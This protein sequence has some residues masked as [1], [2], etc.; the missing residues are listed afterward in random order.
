MSA[1]TADRKLAEPVLRIEDP[2][3]P[4]GERRVCVSYAWKDELSKEPNRAGKVQTLCDR[5]Q[6]AGIAV[7]RDNAVLQP[8]DRLSTFMRTIAKGD[9]I[10]VFLSVAYLRSP[11]CM[12]ELFH[13]WNGFRDEPDA[14]LKKIR[15]FPMPDTKI[16]QIPDR[17]AVAAHWKTQ[18]D[19]ILA[20]IQQNGV[21]VL[22]ETS[23]KQFKYIQDF[24]HH[25]DEMLAQI[26][27]V[28]LQGDL[29]EFIASA[30]AELGDPK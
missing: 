2:P 21:D 26:S 30:I 12:Y 24:A 6:A 23:L 15:V 10:F 22:G 4:Q 7:T 3:R 18:R 16:H 5:L 1:D 8:G 29:D 17:L 11:N 28:L 19:G 13:I 9:V 14:F 27:D 20:A 25:V